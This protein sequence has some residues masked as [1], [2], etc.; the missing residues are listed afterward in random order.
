MTEYRSQRAAPGTELGS[1]NP[2]TA[3]MTRTAASTLSRPA[4]RAAPAGARATAAGGA[5]H[6]AKK[7]DDCACEDVFD[8]VSAHPQAHGTIVRDV[9]RIDEFRYAHAHTHTHAPLAP[10]RVGEASC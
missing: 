5:A 1:L 7:K 10:P 2:A 8:N 4:P 3:T 9:V 6:P